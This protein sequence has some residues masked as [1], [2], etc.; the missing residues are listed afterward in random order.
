MQAYWAR[1]ESRGRCNIDRLDFTGWFDYWHTHLDLYGRGNC[2]PENIPEIAAATVRLLLYMEL[3]GKARPEPIQYWATLC[4]NTMDN[5]VYAHSPN[6][7]GS[8]Y[9]HDFPGVTWDSPAPDWM[10]AAMPAT[11]QLGSASYDGEIVYL[12]RARGE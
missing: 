11:H 6:P 1:A 12:V 9:P 10:M 5:A 4:G 7:N 8:A 2:R 3:R